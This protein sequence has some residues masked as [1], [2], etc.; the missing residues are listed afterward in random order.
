MGST[1]PGE[2]TV[3]ADTSTPSTVVT[4]AED[5]V[6]SGNSVGDAASTGEVSVVM[7]EWAAG[8]EEASVERPVWVVESVEAICRGCELDGRIIGRQKMY[9]R[10]GSKTK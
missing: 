9:D 5:D 3:G 1:G 2:A 7:A 10:T 6:V 8:D 4:V